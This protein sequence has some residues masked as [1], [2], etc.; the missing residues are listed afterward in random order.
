MAGD[1]RA[2]MSELDAQL[3]LCTAE[4]A[5]AIRR[6]VRKAAA[7][8][9]TGILGAAKARASWSTGSTSSP[10]NPHTSIP[11]A[12]AMKTS[13]SETTGGV[14]IRVSA[15]KAP[16]ARAYEFGSARNSDLRHPVFGAKG[17]ESD[18]R[19]VSEATRPF[20]F[21]TVEDQTPAAEAIMWAA[22]DQAAIEAGFI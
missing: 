14:S 1:L 3:K 5:A 17:D 20:L 16:S 8:A 18:W 2:D 9:G 22:M 7:E 12:M 11:E 15:K 6:N 13:F 19:W 4:M 10:R 21:N